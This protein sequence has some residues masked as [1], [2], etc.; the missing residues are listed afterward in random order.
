MNEG[1]MINAWEMEYN[2]NV[3]DRYIPYDARYDEMDAWHGIYID[4]YVHVIYGDIA[5]IFVT[6]YQNIEIWS[7]ADNAIHNK[8]M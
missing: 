1:I 3:L 2:F 4:I 7:Q 5:Q 8:W 6:W